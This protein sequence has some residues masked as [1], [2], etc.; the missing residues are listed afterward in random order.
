[1][2][3][4]TQTHRRPQILVRWGEG[5]QAQHQIWWESCSWGGLGDARSMGVAW[6]AGNWH[7][8]VTVPLAPGH[9]HPSSTQDITTV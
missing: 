1:M 3:A 4:A 9:H 5:P 7:L 2:E 6:A 8:A